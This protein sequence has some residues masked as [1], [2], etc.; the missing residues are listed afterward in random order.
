MSEAKIDM[1]VKQIRPKR[2]AAKAAAPKAPVAVPESITRAQTIEDLRKAVAD[3]SVEVRN[4]L[5]A[6][7]AVKMD[8]I[9]GLD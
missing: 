1:S 6:V 8:E 3:I 9:I 5:G 4:R 2:A 7:L